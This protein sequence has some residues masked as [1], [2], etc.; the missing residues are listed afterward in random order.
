ELPNVSNW[1]LNLRLSQF[2]PVG[3]DFISGV[4]WTLNL[5][6][7]SEFFLQ[8]FNNTIYFTGD[9]GEQVGVPLSELEGVP[10]EELDPRIPLPNNN[11]DLAAIGGAS[12]PAF[13]SDVVDGFAI[14]NFNAGM[15][16]G[17]SEQFRMD[18]FVENVFEQAFSSKAFVN[19]SVNIRYLNAPRIVGLRFRA[20]F[21]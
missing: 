9:N 8:P 16:F 18:L 19:S 11:G 7:R 4:D 2:I 10:I 13:F 12:G 3:G 21:E 17:E 5:L 15:N 1:N 6:Y 14:V 20:F